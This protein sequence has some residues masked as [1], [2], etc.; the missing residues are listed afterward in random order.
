MQ[1][2]KHERSSDME[3]QTIDRT[4]RFPVG[5]RSMESLARARALRPSAAFCAIALLSVALWAGLILRLV[6]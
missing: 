1:P 4:D 2:L 5:D 3:Q 6:L